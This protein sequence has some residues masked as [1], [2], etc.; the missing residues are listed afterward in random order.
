MMHVILNNFYLPE[1]YETV[2]LLVIVTWFDTD[3]LFIMLYISVL[4]G[5]H[6][7]TNLNEVLT[8]Q[9][10]CMFPIDFRVMALGTDIWWYMLYTY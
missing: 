6:C 5:L 3:S 10:L 8:F 2:N 4:L 7:L 9:Y 1:N